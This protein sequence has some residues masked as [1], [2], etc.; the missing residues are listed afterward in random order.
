[1]AAAPQPQDGGMNR[2][3][4][5]H[6]GLAAGLCASFLPASAQENTTPS[7]KVSAAQIQSAVSERFPMSRPVGSLFDLTLAPPAVKLLPQVNRIG[8][9]MD[10][11]AAGPALHRAYTG[12]FDLD[13]G[14]RYEASDKSIRAHQLRVNALRLD[15]LSPQAAQIVDAYGPTLAQQALS[16]AVLYKLQPKDLLLAEGLGLQPGDIKVTDGGLVISFVP[17]PL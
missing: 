16:E 6:A 2:R 10:V 9:S 11:K 14:L 15:G 7:F 1:M 8:T 5:L 3:Q 13:F 12:M 17:K 4:L